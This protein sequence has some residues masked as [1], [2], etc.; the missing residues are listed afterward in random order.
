MKPAFVGVLVGALGFFN[1]AAVIALLGMLFVSAVF[2][3]RRLE[4]AIVAAIAVCLVLLQGAFFAPGASVAELS[5]RFGF[6]ADE[7]SLAGVAK[8]IFMLT[9]P[10]VFMNAAYITAGQKKFLIPFFIFL[11]PA[12]IAF[13]LS[14]TPDIAVNHKYMQITIFMMNIAA[15]GFICFLFSREGKT[16]SFAKTLA[17]LLALVLISTGVFDIAAIYN[18]NKKGSRAIVEDSNATKDWIAENTPKGAVFAAHIHWISPVLLAGRFHF[19]GWPYY[20]WSAGYDTYGRRS[21][22]YNIFNARNVNELHALT[23]S[24]GVDY[25]MIDDSLRSTDEFVLNEQL[26]DESLVRVFRDE[27]SNVSIYLANE[28]LLR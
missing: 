25:I 13:T 8:Y 24:A 2:S 5:V 19:M 17:V 23:E 18:R 15:A 3:K 4:F 22:L 20:P 11:A 28:R 12:A 21:E 9:G 7:V 14:L 16:K 6:I 1:G 26:I 10:L 27:R